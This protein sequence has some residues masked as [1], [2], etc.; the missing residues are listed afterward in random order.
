MKKSRKTPIFAAAAIAITAPALAGELRMADI[1]SIDELTELDGDVIME[2]SYKKACNEAFVKLI[3][4]E[5]SPVALASSEIMV[6]VVVE[7]TGK[8]CKAADTTERTHFKVS[9]MAGN[10]NFRPI[11]PQP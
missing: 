4:E 11:E 10:Y 2:V 5:V 1:S 6:G 8:T 7:D 9:K 3:T